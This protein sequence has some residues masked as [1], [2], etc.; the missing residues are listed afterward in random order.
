MT[1]IDSIKSNLLTLPDDTRVFPG[2]GPDT[3]IGAEKKENPFLN[4]ESGFV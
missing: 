1:L 3:T 2:H 4:Q